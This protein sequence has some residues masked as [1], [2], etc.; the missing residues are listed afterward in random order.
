MALVDGDGISGIRFY[1]AHLGR[2][3]RQPPKL[4]VA[5][6]NRARVTI[7][8]RA[9]GGLAPTSVAH[10]ITEPNRTISLYR[11]FGMVQIS[12][13]GFLPLSIWTRNFRLGQPISVSIN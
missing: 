10:Q 2:F 12:S 6:S 1:H 7:C 8:F 4:G 5:R 13:G 9:L 11:F 3:G